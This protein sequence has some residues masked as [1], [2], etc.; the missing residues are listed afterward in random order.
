MNPNYQSSYQEY[1]IYFTPL[2]DLQGT[3]GNTIN[4]TQNIDISDM[5]LRGTNIVQELDDGDYTVGVFSYG[6][7]TITTFNP[8]GR[9]NQTDDARSMFVVDRDLTKLRID[10][11]DSTNNYSTIWRGLIHEEAT[12]TNILKC[13]TRFRAL[14]NDSIFRKTRIPAGSIQDGNSFSQAINKILSNPIITNTFNY[15]Q[16]NIN[17]NYDGIID[18]GAYFD[19]LDAKKALN[20]LLLASNSVLVIDNDENLIIKGRQHNNN[21]PYKFYGPYDLHNRLNIIDI[22]NWNS[23]LHRVVNSMT[24]NNQTYKDEALI[25]RYRLERK[26]KKMEFITSISTAKAIAGNIVREFGQPRDELEIEVCTESIPNIKLLDLCSINNPLEYKPVKHNE[27]L[28]TY[29]DLQVAGGNCNP[30]PLPIELGC[31]NIDNQIG[32]K[33]TGITRNLQTKNTTLRLREV[34]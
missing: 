14:S 4:V 25:R 19:E 1:Q 10:F 22:K 8:D 13:E 21:E 24:I 30:Q 3:Y 5:V 27:F 11:R 20:E 6:D 33:V 34:D 16:K 7:L 29:N 15:D 31:F 23:G 18:I 2:V 32:W 17:V 28:P 12:R 26:E 9:F